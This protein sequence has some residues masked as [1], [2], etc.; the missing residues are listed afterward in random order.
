VLTIKGVKASINNQTILHNFNLEIKAGETHALM[1]PNGSGKSTIAKIVAG[2]SRYT[3]DKGQIL[4]ETNF[5]YKDLLGMDVSTRAQEGVFLAFQY[6]VEVPGLSNLVFLRSAF[7]SI[8][9]YQGVAE[10]DEEPFKTMAFQKIK[11]LNMEEEFLYRNL[12]EGFSGGEKKQNEI[13]QMMILSP[14]LAILDETDSG[15]DVDSL[16]KMAKGINQFRDKDKGLLL[17]THYHRLL[18][19]VRPDYV[20]ILIDGVIKETGDFSL[21]EKI[22]AQGYDWLSKKLN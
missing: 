15:L 1:G 18:E 22:E 9:R 20:H 8:C 16:Q 3:V 13:L 19:L 6:P 17:I 12:N 14:K 21:A 11:D 7:N 4:Y 2:D 10:M 5:K